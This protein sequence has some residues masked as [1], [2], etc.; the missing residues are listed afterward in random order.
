MRT[1]APCIYRGAR[2]DL[3]VCSRREM[4]TP[5]GLIGLISRADLIRLSL[6]TPRPWC[7]YVVF[8][9]LPQHPSR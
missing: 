6:K 7:R 2:A 5:L 4:R 3:I 1:H 8:E 9:S